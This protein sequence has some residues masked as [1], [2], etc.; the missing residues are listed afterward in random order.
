MATL[1]PRILLKLLQS[2]N[3]HTSHWRPPF[4]APPDR[5]TDLKLTNQLQL[6][7]FVHLDLFVFDSPSV[8]IAAN[9]RPIVVR[10][11]SIRTPEPLIA[12]ISPSRNGGGSG[13]VSSVADGKKSKVSRQVSALKE[14]VIVN[15]NYANEKGSNGR[16]GLEKG[17]KRFLSSGRLKQRSMSSGK[18]ALAV[19]KDTSPAGKSGKRSAFPVPSKCVVVFLVSLWCFPANLVRIKF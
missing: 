13:S 5:D 3:S 19:E 9:M 17:S 11:L 15:V 12:Q 4:L 7:Q 18:K 1:T 10:H 14:N 2:M 8:P 6:G 16:T